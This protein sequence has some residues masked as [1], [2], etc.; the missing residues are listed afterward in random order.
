M[1]A[2]TRPNSND[3][4]CP[5]FA[6]VA[7]LAI[8]CVAA[9]DEPSAG[10][11]A[12]DPEGTNLRLI[13]APDAGAVPFR[14]A[15]HPSWSPAG[16]RIAFT[17]FDPSG[18][19]PEIR[20]VASGG[21]P[22]TVV[23]SGVAPSWS[24]DGARLAYMTSGKPAIATDWS[25]PGRNDERIEVVRL[26]GPDAG[27]IEAVAEG[28]WPRW[29]P[30]DDRL[31]FASRRGATWDIYVRSGSGLGLTRLTDD[32]AMDT[33]PIW[34]PDGAEVVFLS[35]RGVR[36][37]LYRADADASGVVR[38]L[39]NHPR[40]ED[41]AALSPDASR[42]A[43]TD[44]AGRSSSKILLLDLAGEVTRPLL[45]DPF[46]DSDPA[47]SPDGRSLA[48]SSRRPTFP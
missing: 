28:V 34:S 43:F 18:R 2:S 37:D 12:V 6:A 24:A 14:R 46:G 38:R 30:A 21:G 7:A 44:D 29:A 11:F 10:L 9:A 4:W 40:R 5:A 35:N 19:R 39:T 22:S 17:A 33:E 13:A 1:G 23:A 45:S 16:D 31:A 27:A 20:V 8:A 36:W 42:I 41:G 48:F 25:R 15:A 26:E 32:P 47:W 3:A